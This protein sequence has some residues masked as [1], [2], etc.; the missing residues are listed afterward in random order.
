MLKTLLEG[1]KIKHPC[2]NEGL[3]IFISF[4]CK[5]KKIWGNTKDK[6]NTSC[7]RGGRQYT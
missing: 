4:S 5:Q 6:H 3:D 7:H 1:I 2:D